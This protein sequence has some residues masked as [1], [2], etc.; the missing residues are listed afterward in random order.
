MRLFSE[1]FRSSEFL[2]LFSEILS[3][4]SEF[5]SLF[6]GF[7]SLFSEFLSL[8]RELLSIFGEFL[9]L[10]SEFWA[11]LVNFWA[12]VLQIDNF[13]SL[14][15]SGRQKRHFVSPLKWKFERNVSTN[16][17]VSSKKGLVMASSYKS[18]D[19]ERTDH[20]LFS[21]PLSR[22]VTLMEVT[23]EEEG[24]WGVSLYQRARGRYT[25]KITTNFYFHCYKSKLDSIRGGCQ[26]LK[27]CKLNTYVCMFC[28]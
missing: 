5:F 12:T 23:Q 9:R 8:F 6:I 28:M 16:W 27:M 13:V 1:F 17:L 10:F 25:W 14:E 3:L 24:N 22:I 19:R 21:L 18:W 11:Y 20:F 15:K 26:S 7:L 4:F 2:R